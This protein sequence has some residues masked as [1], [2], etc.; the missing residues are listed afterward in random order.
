MSWDSSSATHGQSETAHR[1]VSARPNEE[2]HQSNTRFWYEDHSCMA[3]DRCFLTH[4][5]T[6]IQ[7]SG[8]EPVMHT[9]QSLYCMAFSIE[10]LT[11]AVIA[12]LPER[13]GNTGRVCVLRN[14]SRQLARTQL[15]ACDRGFD[16]LSSDRHTRKMAIIQHIA[17][18][19]GIAFKDL[20]C[21]CP[22]RR[23]VCCEQLGP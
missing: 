14:C 13:D 15:C 2:N 1:S 21:V 16:T 5:G 3:V 17:D 10:H 8:D 12:S 4:A 22:S 23:L 9:S 7:P 19:H 11:H 18:C 6:L 20:V